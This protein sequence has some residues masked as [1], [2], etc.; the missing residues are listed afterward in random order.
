VTA[1]QTLSWRS[2][3]QKRRYSEGLD[4][5]EARPDAANTLICF[6]ADHGDH[7]GDHHD[8]VAGQRPRQ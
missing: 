4:A 1:R 3:A 2:L 7:L 5:V 6:F 8:F